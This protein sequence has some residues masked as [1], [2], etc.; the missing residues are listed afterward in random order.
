MKTSVSSLLAAYFLLCFS[1][2]AFA[3]NSQLTGL[4]KDK[5]DA[6]VPAASV[7][8]TN[9]ETGAVLN[10]KSSKAGFYVFASIVPGRYSLAGDA[11]GF[12]KTIINDVKIDA[13]ANVSQDIVLQVRSSSQSV[14]VVSDPPSEL[15]ETTAAVSTV[16]DRPLI[17]N[18]PLNGNSLSTLFELTPGIVTNA[19]GGAVANGGGISVNGQ[20][21]TSNSLSIDGASGNL[22]VQPFSGGANVMGA[23]IGTSAS[24][25]SN[26]LLPVD[27]IEEFRVQTS[28]Y[29]AEYGRTPGGQIEVKTRGGTNA[30]H[31]SLFENFRNQVM[32]AQDWFI[33]YNNAVSGTTL[34]KQLPLR[35]NDFGGTVGGPILK[36]RLFFFV[37]EENLLMDQP[38][39]PSTSDVP[40][41]QT[42]GSAAAVFRPYLASFPLGNRNNPQCPLS[43]PTCDPNQL[44]LSDV[45]VFSY[46]NTIHDHT[47]SARL[48]AELPRNSHAFFRVNDAPSNF[49]N[50][51]VTYLQTSQINILTLTSGLSSRLSSTILNDLTANYSS[52]KGLYLA[53][54]S[55]KPF[56]QAISSLI[57]VSKGAG[58]FF[59]PWSNL[60]A[61]PYQDHNQLHQFNVADTVS[62]SFGRHT[63][64]T[65]FD[66]RRITPLILVPSPSLS[67]NAYTSSELQG[68]TLDSVQ[69]YTWSG[70]PHIRA[71]NFSLFANDDWKVKTRLTLNLGVRW[72]FNPP[73]TASGP[74]LLAMQ[75]D[76]FDPSGITP[77]SP[78]TALYKT[79]YTNFAPRAGFA[80]SVRDGGSFNTVLR[81]GGGI[82]FDTGQ[83]ATAGQA[84][85]SSYPYVA[86][87]SLPSMPYSSLN[88]NQ[89]Q[90]MAIGL[91]QYSLTL[92]DPNLL[93]PRTYG[94]SLT[95]DQNL[96]KQTVL[97]TSYIGNTAHDLLKENAY[98]N[99]SPSLTPSYG[100]LYVYSNGEN[101]SYNALQTQLRYRASKALNLL[102]SYTFAHALDNGSNDFLSVAGFQKNYRSDS[103]NDIRQILSSAIHYSPRG[104]D[105]TRFLKALTGGWSMDSIVLLQ[106]AAPFSVQSSNPVLDPN[107]YNTY[108]DVVSGVPLYISGSQCAAETGFSCPG[109][110]GLNPAAFVAAPGTRDGTSARNGYRIFGL[111]Q[112]DLGLSRSWP[113]WER[114]SMSFRVDAFD[115][116]NHPDF[117][118]VDNYVGDSTFGRAT[119]TY[120]GT[121]GGSALSGGLNNV[122]SNGGARSLQLSLRIRF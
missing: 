46:S 22:Y 108:A 69:Y 52:S 37:A 54:S 39:D 61:S 93:S 57:D 117:A 42:R 111:A 2:L 13:A 79:R 35:M 97:S 118:S 114:A 120:A 12:A 105:N 5:T 92:I 84:V 87:V 43:D 115:V 34:L 19:G 24:G 90:T 48:D 104:F 82:F 17:E 110:R 96:G 100:F 33:G 15:T 11:P 75:G 14:N 41:A 119:Y 4:V 28:T 94:W 67:L 36:N 8:L 78:G 6:V 64:K 38:R 18:M 112:F 29:S 56:V 66:Y 26:G 101:S 53:Q 16:I 27:A 23:G 121:Y 70:Q 62:W 30:F 88:V 1:S 72:E 89:L 74:G 109:G 9:A 80:Y 103:D 20:R 65:G 55:P 99:L 59:S 3:Q 116:L 77:A 102:A 10:A 85:G 58:Y 91:P 50:P 98:Q 68:G 63:L 51:T 60:V 44:G 81:G 7:T 40:N 25:G 32:D 49:I 31:G 73:P 86:G 106:S 76:P 47:T 113:L 95:I 21:P 122:F 83:A 71:S 107:R 45:Y